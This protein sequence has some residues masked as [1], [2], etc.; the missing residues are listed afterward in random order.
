MLLEKQ[1]CILWTGSVSLKLC[2]VLGWRWSGKHFFASNSL[3]FQ[4][5]CGE[6]EDGEKRQMQSVLPFKQTQ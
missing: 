5:S 2:I 4:R 6:E 1:S 3:I